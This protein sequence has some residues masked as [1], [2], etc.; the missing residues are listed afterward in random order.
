[1]FPAN[2][3]PGCDKTEAKSG[4]AVA[5]LEE[6]EALELRVSE[7]FDEWEDNNP[8]VREGKA[9]EADADILFAE[10]LRLPWSIPSC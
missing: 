10:K 3:A 9:D 2:K 5:E 7:L 8:L 1:V 4:E 6:S